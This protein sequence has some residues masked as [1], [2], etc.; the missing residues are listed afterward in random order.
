MKIL[1]NALCLLLMTAFSASAQTDAKATEILKGVSARYKS[2]KSIAASFTLKMM[3]QKTKKTQQQ[4]GTITLRS[5]QFNLGMADQVVM[6][7]GK[8]N[9]T[10]LK[11]TNEVQISDAKT[12]P[13]AIT[14]ATVFTM[15]E[16]GFKSKFVGEK[17]LNG[18][19]FQII[20]LVPDDNK[21]SYFKI[22]LQIDKKE[23]YVNE[24]RI[25]DKS[26]SIYTYAIDKFTPNADVTDDMFTFNKAKYPGVET[27]DLR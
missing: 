5:N 7:D 17:S 8:T 9:W 2:Y 1:R 12:D 27:V 25:Y 19:T 11:E 6:S 23:R 4:K 13:G 10:Y 3:D 22:Q 26:G 21:K 16:K 14:P 24:A 15:Y 20:E 18:K